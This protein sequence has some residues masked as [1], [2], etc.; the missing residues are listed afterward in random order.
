MV[1]NGTV[2]NGSPPAAAVDEPR[3]IERSGDIDQTGAPEAENIQ[4]P[5]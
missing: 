1:S 2:G 3:D 4:N 5:N